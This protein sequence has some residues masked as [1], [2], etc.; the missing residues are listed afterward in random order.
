MRD[1]RGAVLPIA[2]LILVVLSA[3]LLGLSM[4]TNQEP[5]IASNHVMIVQ[6]QALAEAGLE[7]ALWALSTPESADGI[8]WSGTAVAPYDGS[9]FLGVATESGAMLGGFRLKVSGEGDRQREV[10]TTGLVPGDA[11]PLGRARQDITATLIRLRFPAPPAGLTVRGDLAI[12]AA[13]TV[14]ASAD[15]SCGDRAGTWSS[16]V[17]TAGAGAQVL[18]RGGD[19]AMPNEPTDMTQAQPVGGFDALAFSEAELQALKAVARV[20]GTY[21][22]GGVTFDAS[23]RIPDGV[24]FVDTGSGQPITDATP[25]TDLAA[26]T[27]GE[28]A[29]GP[30]GS[31]RGWLIVN[32]S[33]SIGGDV[34]IQGLAYAADRFSQTGAARVMGAAMAGHVRSTA[35]S[36]VDSRPAGDAALVWSC[37]AGR[38]GGG[39]IPQRWMVKPG[40]YREVAG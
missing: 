30:G 11:G 16:G 15:S 17:T 4:L 7:R 28:G 24:V 29:A 21:Y 2:M 14:D 27:I 23:R 32:G 5:L 37:E 31:F 8:P 18:G 6:A 33:L 36:L 1:Q 13:V 38:T 26:V 34:T 40:S 10:A 39:L 25:A 19:A 22:Q 3:V 12:G 35:P 9:V 20:R